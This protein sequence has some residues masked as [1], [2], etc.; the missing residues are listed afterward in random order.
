MSN[1]TFDSTSFSEQLGIYDFFNVL[2]CGAIFTLGMCAIDINI[3]NYLCNNLTVIKGLGIALMIYVIGMI[4]QETGSK[5]DRKFTKIYRGMN[6]SILKGTV[7][8]N[9]R[10]ETLNKITSN[11]IVLEQYRKHARELCKDYISG[12]ECFENDNANG[13]VFSVCQY[14]VSIKGQD[15]KVERLRALFGMSKTL[16]ACFLLLSLFAFIA[17][18]F[19][20]INSINVLNVVGVSPHGCEHC[21]NKVILAIAFAGMGFIFYVRAKRTMKNFL[22]I[23]LGTY[24]ALKQAEDNTL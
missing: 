15:K 1:I 8:I 6:R 18:F 14:Y 12:D 21:L 7:D 13:F 11:P 24:N 4:L 20:N 9:Y 10:G 16:M 5:L 3:G 23:L 17:L 19:S 22:L 2:L